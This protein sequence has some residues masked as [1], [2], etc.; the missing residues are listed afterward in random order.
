MLAETIRGWVSDPKAMGAAFDTWMRDIPVCQHG[1]RHL[2]PDN[3]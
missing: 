3:Q 1:M 2:L